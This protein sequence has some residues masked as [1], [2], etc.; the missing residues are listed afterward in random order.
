MKHALR[1]LGLILAT[2][3]GQAALGAGYEAIVEFGQRAELGLPVSGVVKTVNVMTGQKIAAGQVLIALDDTLFVAAVARAE[4]EVLRC[5]ADRTVATRDY[6][7]ARQLYERAVLSNVELEN[8]KLNAD[9]AEAACR[10]AQAQLIHG[11]YELEHSK[12]TAPFDGWVLD[13]RAH[14]GASVNSMTEPQPLLVIAAAGE[15]VA[16]LRLPAGASAPLKIGRSARVMIDTRQFE[17]AIET[18]ALEPA[19]RDSGGARYE[20]GI[21]FKTGDLLLRGGQSARVEFP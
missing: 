9:R 17:G 16:R 6:E 13:V 21:A 15:Y 10:Q 18:T 7:Q 2:L 12:I 20:I 8:A 11:K 1:I 4:A 19:S 5:G 3:S 14:A